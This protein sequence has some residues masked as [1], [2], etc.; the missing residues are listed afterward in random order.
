M[1]LVRAEADAAAKLRDA[2]AAHDREA[3][4]AA[5][6]SY[7]RCTRTQLTLRFVRGATA[8]VGSQSH[9]I[10]YVTAKVCACPGGRSQCVGMRARKRSVA[11][12]SLV[13]AGRPLPAVLA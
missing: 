6:R 5:M 13:A 9:A 7:D 10:A 4:N 2:C 3:I 11:V 8:R 12:R 1:L